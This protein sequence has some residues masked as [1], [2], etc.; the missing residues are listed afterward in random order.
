MLRFPRASRSGVPS[1]APSCPVFAVCSG[2]GPS[3]AIFP[4]FAFR[5]LLVAASLHGR[6]LAL[7]LPYV[8]AADRR[9]Q[10]FPCPV[11][12]PFAWWPP[13]THD[14]IRRASPIPRRPPVTHTRRAPS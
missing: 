5:E 11:A 2:R 3:R 12:A 6:H 13:P 10:L 7:Y 14:F 1:R 8:A 4:C 9:G